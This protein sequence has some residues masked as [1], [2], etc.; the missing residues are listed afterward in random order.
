MH[1]WRLRNLM[2]S[3]CCFWIIPQKNWNFVS[4][5]LILDCWQSFH[6]AEQVVNEDQEFFLIQWSWEFLKKSYQSHWA[7]QIIWYY[8]NRGNIFIKRKLVLFTA[9]VF[10]V[11]PHILWLVISTYDRQCLSKWLFPCFLLE[12]PLSTRGSG[13]Q[14]GDHRVHS[15]GHVSSTYWLWHLLAV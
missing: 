13:V 9:I 12:T 7:K 5:G 6:K 4:T 14:W 15:W 1:L 2:P 10:L 3:V 11:K 8:V